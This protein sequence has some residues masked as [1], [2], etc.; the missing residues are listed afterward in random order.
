MIEVLTEIIIKVTSLSKLQSYI[1]PENFRENWHPL[2]QG[3]SRRVEIDTPY[4]E[5]AWYLYAK[6]RTIERLVKG[7]RGRPREGWVEDY[8][9]RYV[10]SLG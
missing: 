9:Y 7:I 3:Y 4:S 5:V 10:E 6:E 8:L 1:N 2:V